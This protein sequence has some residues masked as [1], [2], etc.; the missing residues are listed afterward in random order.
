MVMPS[1]M[2]PMIFGE[3]GGDFESM[4][5]AKE[6]MGNLMSLSNVIAGWK[7]E[8]EPFFYP[9]SEYPKTDAG[10][11]QRVNNNLC[12]IKYFI[13]GLDLSVTDESDF[14]EDGL[15]ALESLGKANALLTEYAELI[16]MKDKEGDK[17]FERRI[18]SIDKLEGLVDDCIARIT[19]GLKEARMRFVEE[20]R[21][22]A[23]TPEERYRARSTKI[24]RNAPCP[25]GSGKKYKK[26]CGLL[27]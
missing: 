17:E 27:H 3:E 20:M 16:E 13:K 26:C 19:M 8:S 1:K 22:L 5:E 11:T 2:M 12:F 4:E 18:D 21:R 10:L 23:N 14:S 7:P 6:V 15:Q 25:C 24:S 9:H